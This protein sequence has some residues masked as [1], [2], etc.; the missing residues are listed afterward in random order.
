MINYSID[1]YGT[2]AWSRW[3][4]WNIS[5]SVHR[6]SSISNWP[7]KQSFVLRPCT[8]FDWKKAVTLLWRW[9][10]SDAILKVS[11]NVH[12]GSLPVPQRR[13]CYAEDKEVWRISESRNRKE[14]DYREDQWRSLEVSVSWQSKQ[15][16]TYC[17]DNDSKKR[18]EWDVLNR[19]RS[20][21]SSM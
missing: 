7:A 5:V 15:A 16:R 3:C 17:N 10:W 18:S 20:Q 13:A 21:A 8:C 19:A 11:G 14:K 2:G 12:D 1:G 6:K 9:R 4:E